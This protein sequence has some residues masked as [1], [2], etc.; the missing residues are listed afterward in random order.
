MENGHH[1]FS[2]LKSSWQASV[3]IVLVL[4][5]QWLCGR[6]LAPRWRYALWL[7]VIAR[8][9][10]PWTVPSSVSLF[11]WVGLPG[12]VAPTVQSMRPISI[13][14]PQASPEQ[15]T[16]NIKRSAGA[17]KAHPFGKAA[18]LFKLPAS[19]FLLVW[20]TGAVLLTLYLA[21]VHYRL[22]SK[23]A[24]CRPLI[25]APTLNLLEDCKQVMRVHTPV[26]LVETGTCGESSAVRIY[27]TPIVIARRPDPEFL[28]VGASLGVFA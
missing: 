25:D 17:D 28:A 15:L 6:R 24:S 1:L 11:N 21:L 22:F 23:V 26:T 4:A 16:Q 5:I 12:N 8:L 13:S 2:L 14:N 10:L 7:L 18:A 27:S 19:G 3:L 9:A 20:V